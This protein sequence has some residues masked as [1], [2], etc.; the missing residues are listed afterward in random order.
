MKESV[1]KSVS[2]VPVIGKG[3]IAGIHH[4]KDT[5]K[6]AVIDGVIFEELGFKYFGPIDGPVSYTHL[7]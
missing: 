4:A 7:C 3:V 5:I 1:K 6:Y 2:K